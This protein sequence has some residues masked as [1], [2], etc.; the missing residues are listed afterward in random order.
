M[1][2]AEQEAD[3]HPD[4]QLKL[5]VR[6]RVG[7]SRGQ[8]GYSSSLTPAEDYDCLEM[9]VILIQLGDMGEGGYTRLPPS[10]QHLF[11]KSSPLRWHEGWR[12]STLPNSSFEKR[13]HYMIP[14]PRHSTSIDNLLAR[15]HRRPAPRLCSPLAPVTWHSPC[16]P[17][18]AS[19]LLLLHTPLSGPPEPNKP[20]SKP[21][22]FRGKASRGQSITT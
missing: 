13:V 14:V 8:W 2:A 4:H 21:H 17:P 7:R 9:S 1:Y 6:L 19:P 5:R 22:P 16:C 18:T 15:G 20:L 11:R 3:G 12:V 10:L